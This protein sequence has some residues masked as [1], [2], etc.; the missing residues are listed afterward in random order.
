MDRSDLIK[1]TMADAGNWRGREACVASLK[2][3]SEE[4]PCRGCRQKGREQQDE[5]ARSWCLLDEDASEDPAWDE[6]VFVDVDAEAGPKK[7]M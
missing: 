5:V 2:G 4:A 3:C 7:K 6:V 1:K